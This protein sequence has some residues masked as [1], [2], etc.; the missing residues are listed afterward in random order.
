[1]ASKKPKHNKLRLV[2]GIDRSG[3]MLSW[4]HV[5]HSEAR[6]IIQI[7]KYLR[8]QQGEVYLKKMVKDLK[9]N[10]ITALRTI[11]GLAGVKRIDMIN[12]DGTYVKLCGSIL[13]LRKAMYN[14][15]RNVSKRYNYLTAPIKILRAS[16]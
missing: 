9:Y 16:S 6:R 10:R 8:G 11:R 1:M 13:Y 14:K 12:N 4:F 3:R 15:R 2:Y 5:E 7:V